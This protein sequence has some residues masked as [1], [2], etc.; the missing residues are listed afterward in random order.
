[1]GWGWGLVLLGGGWFEVGWW[2]GG[3]GLWVGVWFVGGGVLVWCEGL[4]GLCLLWVCVLLWS[5][6]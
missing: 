5:V 4:R 3:W 1:M 6:C 2:W